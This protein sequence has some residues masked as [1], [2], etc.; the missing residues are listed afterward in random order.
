M[1]SSLKVPPRFLVLA[2]SSS[3]GVLLTVPPA[4]GSQRNHPELEGTL[5][6]VE[7]EVIL[8]TH[9]SKDLQ[10]PPPHARYEGLN[11]T[12]MSA[13]P[14]LKL[15][16]ESILRTPLGARARVVYP[17][18]DQLNLA[19]G[20]ELKTSWDT[21]RG[22]AHVQYRLTHGGLRGVFEKGGP[23]SRTTVRTRTATMGVRGTDFFIADMPHPDS[24]EGATEV[25]LLRGEVEVTP[26]GKNLTP[27]A[28]APIRVSQG[29]TAQIHPALPSPPAPKPASQEKL[30]GLQVATEVRLAPEALQKSEN[31]LVLEKQAAE[32][33]LRDIRTHDPELHARLLESPTRAKTLDAQELNARTVAARLEH[34]PRE[35]PKRSDLEPRD[36]SA[37]DRYFE[38]WKRKTSSPELQ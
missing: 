12:R 32:T 20:T 31:L 33:T 37:Y 5:T 14:G 21:Q 35:K 29:L 38:P 30:L 16:R 15:P 4:S 8:L 28:V 17:N 2:L 34:A 7:G 25:T 27:A 24:P 36:R 11:Y 22:E 13:R 26:A 3:L 23:R 1:R 10:I 18:G 6:A 9:P 19:P